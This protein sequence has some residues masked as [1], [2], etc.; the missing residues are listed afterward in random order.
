MPN[1]THIAQMLCTTVIIVSLSII[2]P[3]DERIVNKL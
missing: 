1:K 3:S 2:N